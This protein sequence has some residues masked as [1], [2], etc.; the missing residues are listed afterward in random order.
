VLRTPVRRGGADL[1]NTGSGI[2][3][4]S[5]RSRISLRPVAQVV[6]T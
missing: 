6:R 4:S 2:A 3:V 5:S 1:M